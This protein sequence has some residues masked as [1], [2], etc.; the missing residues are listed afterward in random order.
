MLVVIYLFLRTLR[1]T[2][3]PAVAIPV[4]IIGTFSILYFAGFTINTLTLMGLTL[5]IGLVVDDAIVVLENITRWVER[6]H[7]A[8]RGGDPRHAGDLVRGGGVDGLGGRRVPAARVPDRHDR[9]ALR[10]VRRDG[11]GGALAISGFV[12]LTLSPALAAR[13]LR[14][15]GERDGHARGARARIDDLTDGYTSL[16]RRAMAHRGAHGRAGRRL[17]RA[18]TRHALRPAPS[19][20]SSSRPPTAAASS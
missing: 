8:A 10:R 12:A 15:R 4:S 1:A 19:I 9:A 18:R 5:A 20:A 13:V 11:R 7:A 17:V 3:V 2:L 6:R 16:L 14:R